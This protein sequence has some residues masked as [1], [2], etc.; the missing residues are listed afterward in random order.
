MDGGDSGADVPR[1]LLVFRLVVARSRSVEQNVV[2]GNG[3]P[4]FVAGND[5]HRYRI[6]ESGA[7]HLQ[8]GVQTYNC[9]RYSR[10]GRPHFCTVIRRTRGEN[11]VLDRLVLNPIA[12][13]V[14]G[15]PN[16][17][18]LSALIVA[19]LIARFS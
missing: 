6:F 3:I 11:H 13:G 8:S 19:L 1:Y 10:A 16:G 7:C 2:W 18:A 9:R 4:A 5:L 12:E 14:C 15:F 17:F